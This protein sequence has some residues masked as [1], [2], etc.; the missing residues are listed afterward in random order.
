MSL[1]K[2]FLLVA[3]FFIIA[4]V[5]GCQQAAEKTEIEQPI[6]PAR[7]GL[8]VHISHG[9]DDPHRVLMGLQMAAIMAQDHDVLVY[10]DINGVEVV[11]KDSKDLTYAH[12]ESSH[13]QLNDLLDLGVPV[14]ACPGCLKAA[15]KSLV[16]LMPGVQ[17]A[18]KDLFFTFTN[19]RIVTLDY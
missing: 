10:F 8:L 1:V 3:L 11:Y 15:G 7:D 2:S 19:G 12:F 6:K 16:D 14:L 18:D 17:L 5:P 9:V 13:A 4:S